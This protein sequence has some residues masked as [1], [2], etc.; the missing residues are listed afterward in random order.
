MRKWPHIHLS[1]ENASI[2]HQ[3]PQ[4]QPYNRPDEH[5]IWLIGPVVDTTK[6]KHDDK[7]L[8][9][10]INNSLPECQIGN[11]DII[12]VLMVMMFKLMSDNFINLPCVFAIALTPKS[13]VWC[14]RLFRRCCCLLS[15]LSQMVFFGKRFPIINTTIYTLLN[16]LPKREW[17]QK[18]VTIAGTK[19]FGSEL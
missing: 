9:W 5:S 1:E 2:Y 7:I 16:T 17:L 11:R 10:T 18:T 4:Y 12:P 14:R 19:V 6:Q 13:I 8:C 15:S 3:W